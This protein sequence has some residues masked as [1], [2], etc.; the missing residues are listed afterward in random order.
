M[1]S[2]VIVAGEADGGL[3]SFEI[4]AN[5]S[6]A[7]R[8]DV[9]L[10]ALSGTQ[11]VRDLAAYEVG[12]IS[13]IIPSGRYDDNMS[14]Y[15]VEADGT[16]TAVSH[17]TNADGA[18][19]NLVSTF[20]VNTGAGTVVYSVNAQGGGIG[21]SQLNADGTLGNIGFFADDNA[22]Y[23][24]DVSAM[25][26]AQLHGQSFMFAASTFDAGIQSFRVGPNGSLTA[27]HMLDDSDIGFFNPSAMAAVQI[28]S[29]GFVIM[30]AAGTDELVVMRVSHNGVMKVVDRFVDTNETRFEQIS[31]MKL[32]QYNG[33]DLIFVSGSDDGFS[34]LEIDYRGRLHLV[35]TVADD[36]DT[37]LNNID[38][39]EIVEIGGRV[40]IFAASP[41]EHGFTQFELI[42]NPYTTITGG[43]QV[44][45]LTGG[46]GNDTID[47]RGGRDII[48]GGG[49]DDILI[50]GRGTDRMTG[51]EG[52]D[53]FRFRD[54]DRM[55]YIMDFEMGIDK[56]DL[57]DFKM[58]YTIQ[59]IEIYTRSNGALLVVGDDRFRVFNSD[60]TR[61]VASDFHPD[62]FIF[63]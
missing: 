26:H 18:F 13:Y 57:S 63:V 23:I 52:A 1:R 50:D 27:T 53:I 32:F 46:A 31:T 33:R 40:F 4:M 39:L 41:T 25:S 47:G 51:G 3:S 19:A 15:R 44:Q 20:G 59:D 12:G 21:I 36:F 54:D 16:L 8:D 7:P 48:D 11:S 38:D 60:G 5:G 6:L 56:I 61:L 49:G 34:V 45:V 29:R 22:R 17:Y 10:S 37:T 43:R 30:G 35:A 62:D 55:D 24:N 9:I 2:F 14:I 42:L 58:L 28:G